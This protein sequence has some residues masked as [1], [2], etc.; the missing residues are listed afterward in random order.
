MFECFDSYTWNCMRC[1][2]DSKIIL[3][4]GKELAGTYTN[5]ITL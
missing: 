3:Q 4:S 1:Y 5:K 2:S